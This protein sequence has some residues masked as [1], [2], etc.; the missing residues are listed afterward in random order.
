MDHDFDIL[1]TKLQITCD[2]SVILT[3][4]SVEEV[5]RKLCVAMIGANTYSN[6]LEQIIN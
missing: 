2:W 6:V 1:Q 5:A 4:A 3:W